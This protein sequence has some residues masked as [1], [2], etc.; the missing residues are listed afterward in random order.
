MANS[1]HEYVKTF[2][3]A[4]TLLPSTYIVVRIDGRGFHKCFP[5]PCTP[6]SFKNLQY[7]SAKKNSPRFSAKYDFEKPN[8]RRALDLMN[9]AALAVMKEVPD[10]MFAYGIS[11][12]FRR[13]LG[14]HFL[15]HKAER[16]NVSVSFIFDRSC[17]LF[18][19]RER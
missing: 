8:D 11:D 18:D 4:T 1:K 14:K 15:G 2:E 9:A 7:S 10:I 13:V 6:S 19:R 12:E 17:R 5:P 3:Q 16:A